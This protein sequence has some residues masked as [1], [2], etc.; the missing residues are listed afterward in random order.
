MIL[1]LPDGG[2]DRQILN[3][4]VEGKLYRR[5]KKRTGTPQAVACRYPVSRMPP[6]HDCACLVLETG[7][8]SS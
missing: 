7:G 1:A 2:K 3:P 8:T 5:V 4:L 6:A